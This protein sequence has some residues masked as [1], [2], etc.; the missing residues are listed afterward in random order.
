MSTALTVPSFTER[1][2]ETIIAE[3][4]AYYESLVGKTVQPG[5]PEMSLINTWAY[6][7]FLIRTKIQSAGLSML[8]NFSEAPVLDFLAQ[9]VSVTRL[10]ASPAKCTL[11]FTLIE[12]HGEVTIPAGT[13]VQS[14]DGVVIFETDIEK[15]IEVGVDTIE[16]PATCSTDG[17]LGN[18]YGA[19]DI[20]IPLDPYAY[21]TLIENLA[22]T[23]GG[24]DQESDVELRDRIKLAPNSF[25]TA[26]PTSGYIFWAK[27]AS[28]LIIDVTAVSETAGQMNVYP[29]VVGGGVTPP[30]VIEAVEAVLNGE[31]TIP[32]CDT[33]VVLAPEKVDYTIVAV[34]VLLEGAVGSEVNAVVTAALNEYADK[35]K[36]TLGLDAIENQIK[37]ICMVAGVYNVSLTGFTDV[38][39]TKKQYA[40]CTTITVTNPTENVG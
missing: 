21:V 31:K 11:S 4:K 30:E 15:V 35:R 37:A 5:Q 40:F 14:T 10:A 28:A 18:G 12:G 19:G 33:V 17:I 8:V 36:S 39:V 27:S 24:A 32:L 16:I 38:V 22:V 6:R 7:E 20:S 23:A 29:L 1:N 26:G 13:R 34:L 9:G 25:S 2:I 3:T